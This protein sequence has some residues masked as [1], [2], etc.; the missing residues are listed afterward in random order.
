MRRR[1][2]TTEGIIN[3]RSFGL[4]GAR[5]ITVRQ[6]NRQSAAPSFSVQPDTDHIADGTGGLLQRNRNVALHK[7]GP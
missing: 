6:V 7:D 4:A 1:S 5:C 3:G 2:L